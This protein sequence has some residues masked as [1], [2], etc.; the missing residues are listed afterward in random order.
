MLGIRSSSS[1]CRSKTSSLVNLVYTCLMKH[2]I[3]KISVF[4][5][6]FMMG[7]GNFVYAASAESCKKIAPVSQSRGLS[8][9]A[10][11]C[12][13]S[14]AAPCQ[15]KITTQAKLFPPLTES[16]QTRGLFLSVLG[17][18]AVQNFTS[19]D[20]PIRRAFSSKSPPGQGSILALYSVYRI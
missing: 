16:L 7:A 1:D 10:A 20:S 17:F 11:S 14:D 15:C 3:S 13:K 19:N 8:Q 4:I 12:C 2:L 6:I 9:K 18:A 5:V